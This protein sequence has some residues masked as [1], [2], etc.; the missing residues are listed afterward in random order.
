MSRSLSIVIALLVSSGT[1]WAHRSFGSVETFKLSTRNV[2]ISVFTE[3][4]PSLADKFTLYSPAPDLVTIQEQ[5]IVKGVNRLLTPVYVNGHAVA[6]RRDGRFFYPFNL[7][8]GPQ[9]IYVSYVSSDGTKISSLKR[10]V[11]RFG[12]EVKTSGNIHTATDLFFTLN[13]IPNAATRDPKG[14]VTRGD[15]AVLL[16]KLSSGN[17]LLRTSTELWSP[18]DLD[19][20]SS[21]SGAVPKI[22]AYGLMD[23]YSD[24]QFRPMAPISQFDYVLGVV[25]ALGLPLRATPYNM[26]YKNMPSS[27]WPSKYIAT[28]FHAQL[29]DPSDRFDMGAPVT[30]G[31]LARWVSNIKSIQAV[32]QTESECTRDYD[33]DR[34]F[35]YRVVSMIVPPA[36][37]PLVGLPKQVPIS[38]SIVPG[39][40]RVGK[41]TLPLIS[42]APVVEE[43][44]A[45]LRGHWLEKTVRT[46]YS[47]GLLSALDSPSGRTDHTLFYPRA[48]ISRGEFARLILSLYRVP[49]GNLVAVVPTDL[50]PT[51]IAFHAVSAMVSANIF[52]PDKAGKVY[53]DRPLTKIESLVMIER[54]SGIELTASGDISLPFRDVNSK[55]WAAPYLQTA[56]DRKL[57]SPSMFYLPLFPIT[58]AEVL[59]LI[60]KTPQIVLLMK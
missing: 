27:Y 20:G 51:H 34:R 45:D 38:G 9:V 12:P 24:G 49:S 13:M 2:D 60:A 6:V 31:N 26:P 41:G 47:K 18:T 21:L 15:L 8:L 25:K 57:I 35:F 46:L 59:A 58:R 54:A 48:S 16:M 42:T 29:I 4:D 17:T 50:P 33:A 11:H 5:L 22:V 19:V 7:K 40:L 23:V 28:A 37:E 14:L 10:Q 56:L 52:V 53:P 32:Y 1:L 30:I 55:S 36:V 44:Y 43:V 39:P 3:F